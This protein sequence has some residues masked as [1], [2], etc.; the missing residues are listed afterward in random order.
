MIGL[1]HK[2]VDLVAHRP[3]RLQLKERTEKCIELLMA[4]DKGYG[5]VST[6]AKTYGEIPTLLR[7]RTIFMHLRRIQTRGEA[8]LHVLKSF[9]QSLLHDKL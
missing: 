1:H 2:T 8:F 9:M 6:P 7:K 5:I 4:A 3:E